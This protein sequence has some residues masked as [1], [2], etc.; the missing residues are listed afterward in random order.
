MPGASTVF[1]PGLVSGLL[2]SEPGAIL[3]Q[4][5][6]KGY[7]NENRMSEWYFSKP[8]LVIVPDVTMLPRT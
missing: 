5:N 6:R 4:K 3:V 1:P 8:G 2:R 7:V